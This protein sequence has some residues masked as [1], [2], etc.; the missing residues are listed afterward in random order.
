MVDHEHYYRD[1]GLPRGVRC[2]HCNL[3]EFTQARA[4]I[5]LVR[6]RDHARRVRQGQQ[7]PQYGIPIEHYAMELLVCFEELDDGMTHTTAVP[8]GW[9]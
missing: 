1:F 2:A 7:N 9:Q 8:E 5:L 6:M 3:P 4:D